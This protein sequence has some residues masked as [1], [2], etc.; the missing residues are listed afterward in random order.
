MPTLNFYTASCEDRQIRLIGGKNYG[1]V[2]VCGS[3]IWGTVCSDNYW[4]DVDAGVVCKS[5][6][7]SKYGKFHAMRPQGQHG[8]IL[9]KCLLM[10]D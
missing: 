7:F 1:R 8:T 9:Y 6:G 10:S 5:L 3:G 4:D 2:E